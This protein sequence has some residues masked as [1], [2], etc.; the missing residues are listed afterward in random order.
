MCS[1]LSTPF[2]SAIGDILYDIAP[3]CFKKAYWQLHDV[4][5]D[6][7]QTIQIYSD[8]PWIPW[9]LMRPVRTNISTTINTQGIPS[10]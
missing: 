4:L 1:F 2:S 3:D 5:G 6:K 9:E 8:E 10:S 7:F